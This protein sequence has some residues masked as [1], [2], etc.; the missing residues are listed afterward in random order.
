MLKPCKKTMMCLKRYESICRQH[1][2]HKGLRLLCPADSCS[3]ERMIALQQ[4]REGQ[5]SSRCPANMCHNDSHISP[6]QN[7]RPGPLL[8]R[9]GPCR[10]PWQQAKRAQHSSASRSARPALRSAPLPEREPRSARLLRLNRRR[11]EVGEPLVKLA[12]SVRALLA[13]GSSEC[14]C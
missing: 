6:E 10:C 3:V 8:R 12:G 9:S 2:L 1:L 4:A 11:T 5:T 14:S 7:V 13:E